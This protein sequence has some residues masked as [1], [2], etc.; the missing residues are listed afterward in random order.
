VK[1]IILEI[2]ENG[3]NV[4]DTNGCFHYVSGYTDLAVGSEITFEDTPVSLPVRSYSWKKPLLAAS[5]VLLFSIG[6]FA[7]IFYS[8]QPAEENIILLQSDY[9]IYIDINPSVELA[10]DSEG[11]V[12][13]VSGLNE[14]GDTLLEGANLTGTYHDSIKAI[15][16]SAHELGYGV[17]GGDEIWA[18]ITLVASDN[19]IA[20]EMCAEIDVLLR[21]EGFNGVVVDY[22]DMDNR[23]RAVSLD[24]SP[25]K[26]KLV[27]QL[28]PL[29]PLVTK[30]DI[31]EMRVTDIFKSIEEASVI[32]VPAEDGRNT[33]DSSANES[34]SKLM[35]TVDK[36]IPSKTHYDRWWEYGILCYISNTASE[37]DYFVAFSGDFWDKYDYAVIEFGTGNNRVYT[38]TFYKNYYEVEGTLY[39]NYTSYTIP[40]QWGTHYSNGLGYMGET[41]TGCWF[42]NPLGSG[43][44]QANRLRLSPIVQ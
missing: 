22:W 25:G 23:N 18:L 13:S 27:E 2:K 8:T 42:D 14:D 41:L 36:S 15:L 7:A 5:I 9:Y 21:T 28:N 32:T 20:A 29:T 19:A 10:Y 3:V 40:S 6:L 44:R 1:G 24:I 33:S 35:L 34:S 38:A 12:Q 4:M 39:T 26:L 43:S 37:S 30:E 31:E 16:Y 11:N 17:T